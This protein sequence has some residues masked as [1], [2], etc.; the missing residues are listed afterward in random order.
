ME[1]D[2]TKWNHHRHEEMEM[3]MDKE[4]SNMTR[5]ADYNPRG[6]RKGEVQEIL[7]PYA[8]KS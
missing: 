4:T 6:K 7:G 2:R 1:K 3:D 8:H 5:Q